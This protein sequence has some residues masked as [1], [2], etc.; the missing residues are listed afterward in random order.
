MLKKKSQS[1]AR[2]FKNSSSLKFLPDD[3]LEIFHIATS[4]ALNFPKLLSTTKKSK[5]RLHLPSIKEIAE[6]NAKIT[7][8]PNYITISS[9]HDLQWHW[10]LVN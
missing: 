1:K 3:L 2:K 10:L 9:M 8:E 6:I 4:Q 7:L 5:S